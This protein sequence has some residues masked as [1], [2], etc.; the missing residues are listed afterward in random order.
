MASKSS[1]FEK[2]Y[3]L[4]TNIILQD[5]H[6]IITLSDNSENLVIIPETVLDE[7]D[8][9]K[10][11]FEEINYQAREFGRL[12]GD[13]EVISM[14]SV[15]GD[16]KIIELKINHGHNVRVDIISKDV[17]KTDMKSV[18]MNIYNDR[19]ILEIA[20]FA[21]DHYLGDDDDKNKLV[22]LSLDIMARTR[23][24]SLKIPTETLR[25]DSEQEFDY[26]FHKT[27]VLP[28]DIPTHEFNS[29]PVAAIDDNAKAYNF[30]YTLKMPSGKEVLAVVK[31]GF[32]N[33]IDEDEL[34]KQ[35]V[36]PKNKEQLFFSH[37][38]LDDFFNVL[39]VDARAGSGKTLLAVSA[40]MK[41]IRK[42]QYSKIVYIRNSIE[43][44]DRGEEIGFLS[45]NDEK[46]KIYNHPL[47]DSIEYI[48]RSEMKKSINNKP[49]GKESDMQSAAVQ[50]RVLETIEQYG[51]ETAWVGELRGRT[52]TNSFVIID[53]AQNM[54]NKTLQMVLTRI[55]SSS[56][57][58]I[59][60]SNKQIDNFYTN[61]HTNGLSTLLNSTQT[62][63][64]E[65]NLFSIT[66]NKVLRG[67]ITE[68][69]EKVFSGEYAKK[70]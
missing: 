23:A 50:E 40:A 12:L 16:Y 63:Y 5:A 8:A 2:Y 44:L 69:S 25:G 49:G 7:L 65:V 4:D 6:S 21:V 53:E 24:L 43:S 42:K 67:P 19:K 9:K 57:V 17:Y 48:V 59:L 26:E 29:L 64:D 41:K 28:T 51:I 58:V 56:K 54:S 66:L 31:N 34:R 37:A 52:I 70:D 60:G 1:T 47:M 35:S 39:V 18:P 20:G 11:G 10:S 38:L 30:S 27:I 61:R 33:P 36:S 15:S 13:A 46:F 68:W 14:N 3:V 62:K 22:F 45:G 55:D 32:L